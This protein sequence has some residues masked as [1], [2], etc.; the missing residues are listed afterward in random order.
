[1]YIYCIHTYLG[2]YSW[3]KILLSLNITED[4]Y[5]CSSCFKNSFYYICMYSNTPRHTYLL[6][7]FKAQVVRGRPVSLQRSSRPQTGTATCTYYNHLETILLLYE[8]SHLYVSCLLREKGAGRATWMHWTGGSHMWWVESTVG[9][10]LAFSR[11]TDCRL[12]VLL[13]RAQCKDMWWYMKL[14][15][16][17]LMMLYR[18]VEQV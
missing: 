1:M 8:S 7:W 9:W 15:N 6:P 3:Y 10:N 18:P 14:K 13:R 4:L 11:W 12:H 16:N 5:H 2:R 17:E